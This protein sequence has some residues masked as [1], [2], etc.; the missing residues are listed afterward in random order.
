MPMIHFLPFE[1]LH[2]VIP[3]KTEEDDEEEDVKT[4]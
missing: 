1:V 3:K 4:T 2:K